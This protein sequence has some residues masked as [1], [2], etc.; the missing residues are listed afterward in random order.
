MGGARI[1]LCQ[2]TR[3]GSSL[4]VGQAGATLQVA[5]S[6]ESQGHHH[7]LLALHC[8]QLAF[9]CWAVFDVF[10]L[11]SPGAGEREG[12]EQQDVGELAVDWTWCQ[13]FCHDF[14]PDFV[15]RD[16]LRS[17]ADAGEQLEPQTRSGSFIFL[18]NSRPN[19]V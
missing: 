14:C 11:L 9:Q 8:R 10:L 15:S 12:R 7:Q 2:L 3:V 13:S 1:Y 18:W 4:Q 16:A 6:L 17:P 5:L 19:G